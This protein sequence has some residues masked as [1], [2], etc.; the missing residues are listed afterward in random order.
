MSSRLFTEVRERRGL[1]YYVYGLNHSYTDAGTLY[2]QAGVD[3]ARID[4][5]VATIAA[6]LRKIAAEP[7]P[8]EEL[9]KARNFAKGR[10]VLQLESPQGL[11]MFGL[12]KE[13]LERRL[14]DPDEVVRAL[15]AVTS[16]DVARVAS[17]LIASDRLR[18]A[19]IGPFDDASRFEQLLD[20]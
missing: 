20:G 4:D 17:E 12:R 10:F 1:A 14:P 11:M 13:V 16:D 15:D 5:A 9:E 18:L 8:A 2:A 6:E 19:V 3:I 7:L